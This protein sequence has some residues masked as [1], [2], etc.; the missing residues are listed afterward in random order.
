MLYTLIEA[1]LA[2]IAQLR[3]LYIN[4]SCCYVLPL[5]RKARGLA[6]HGGLPE[7]LEVS[8]PV[9]CDFVRDE[10]SMPPALTDHNHF[11]RSGA[12]LVLNVHKTPS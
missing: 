9:G 1:V 2:K 8:D 10:R 7:W 11:P 6:Q 12:D 5:R 3:I 4:S